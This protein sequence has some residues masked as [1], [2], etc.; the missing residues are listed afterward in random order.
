[1]RARL[2]TGLIRRCLPAILLSLAVFLPTAAVAEERWL[3]VSIAGQPVGS[4]R[5]SVASREGAL[6]TETATRMVINRLGH[7]VEVAITSTSRES[8][9]GRLRDA[10][11]DLKMSDQ[12]T[13]TA[14]EVGEG[15]V[16]LRSQAGGKGFERTVPFSGE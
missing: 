5:E 3:L 12:T 16:R 8:A 6:V 13:S 11:A 9:E 14:V 1:M 15:T 4:L 10:T 2:F 7:R